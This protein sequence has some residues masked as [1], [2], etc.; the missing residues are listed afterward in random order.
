M[1]F[2]E[3]V[4]GI[5]VCLIKRRDNCRLVYSIEDSCVIY[6]FWDTISLSHVFRNGSL[7]QQLK[8]TNYQIV[9]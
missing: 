1:L 6:V 9:N 4:V 8:P 7:I 3:V 2:R 5:I